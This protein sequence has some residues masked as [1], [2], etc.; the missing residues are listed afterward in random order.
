MRVDLRSVCIAVVA[1]ALLAIVFSMRG[2]EAQV[3]QPAPTGK[4]EYKCA[5]ASYP[6]EAM[7]NRYGKDGWEL[8]TVVAVRK[9]AFVSVF[10]RKW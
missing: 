2:T 4:W 8:V 7:L 5:E 10:K 9:G 3:P 6:N 1:V